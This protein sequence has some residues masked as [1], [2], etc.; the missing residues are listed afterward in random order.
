MHSLLQD[1]QKGK[2]L[3][4]EDLFTLLQ[5]EKEEDCRD[6]YSLAYEVKCRY[7][8]KKVSFRALIEYSNICTKNC[9]YCGIRRDN[10]K[11]TRYQMGEEEVLEAA[12]WAYEQGFG[13][14][15]LQSGERE[16]EAFINR[17]DSLVKK[18]KAF[19]NGK[20]GI[21]LSCGE[22]TFDV[23]KRWFDSGA[24]RYLLRIEASAEEFYK[25]LHPA[26]HSYQRRIQCL[27]D[28]RKAGYQTGSGVM[29]GLPGQKIEH[30]VND[31][32]FFRE[33]DLDMIGM[34]P[35]IP[36]PDTLLTERNPGFSIPNEKLLALAL[37]MIACTRLL[38]KDVNIA[39]TTALHTLRSNGREEGLRA[40]ANVIM[41]NVTIPRYKKSYQL[42]TGK[43]ALDDGPENSLLLLR[44]SI[45]EMGEEVLWDKWGDSPH[46]AARKK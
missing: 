45:E 33:M 46:F 28:L 34:G 19:S 7:I 3:E 9:F 22:Q 40:G 24:H 8:G 12:K 1:L 25:T 11:T 14:L 18:I 2:T 13:S 39:A 38:L 36:H 42:Y 10:H 37:K 15:V 41:P 4:K 5:L 32:L 21:T 23:Y 6:L 43:S 44:Q 26:D 31:L 30:M 20:L 16:D 27:R 17:I 29:F 35:Y